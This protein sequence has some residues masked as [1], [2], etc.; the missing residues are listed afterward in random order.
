MKAAGVKPFEIDAAG[1]IYD[2]YDALIYD[3]GRNHGMSQRMLETLIIGVF[4][5]IEHS[6]NLVCI[7]LEREHHAMFSAKD[8]YGKGVT[9]SVTYLKKV[10]G[11]DFPI[12]K[13]LIEDL[14]IAIIIR[15]SLVHSNAVIRDE[16]NFRKISSYIKLNPDLLNI[17]EE[18]KQ[19][20]LT[21]KYAN[22]LINLSSKICE[23]LEKL[24]KLN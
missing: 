5:F 15:N 10:L 23:D 14:D 19:I 16:K 6:M 20:S 7:D 18:L 8:L 17:S 12:D 9:R 21:E 13:R 11:V 22:E 3:A 24:V 4:I 1:D 2:P